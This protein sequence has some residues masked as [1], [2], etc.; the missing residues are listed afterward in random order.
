MFLIANFSRNN[1]RQIPENGV[2][3]ITAVH[4]ANRKVQARGY[5]IRRGMLELQ[6]TITFLAPIFCEEGA[7][8]II[9]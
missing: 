1:R 2:P 7:A 3:R 5:E 9:C 6:S 8:N 4:A